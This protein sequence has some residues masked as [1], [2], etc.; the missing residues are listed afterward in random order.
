MT[1]EKDCVNIDFDCIDKIDD[2]TQK[3]KQFNYVLSEEYIIE[4]NFDNIL[5]YDKT[6][7]PELSNI[8]NNK[9]NSLDLSN[10]NINRWL[11]NMNGKLIFVDNNKCSSFSYGQRK[12]PGQ[13]IAM[14]EMYSFIANLMLNYKFEATKDNL[15]IKFKE[16]LT[17]TVNPQIPIIPKR[18]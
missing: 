2:K 13:T 10:F 3:K 9:N 16:D 15:K 8:N 14:K 11:K 4:S 12:C 5:M 1:E 18:R 17:K 6:I 7:W